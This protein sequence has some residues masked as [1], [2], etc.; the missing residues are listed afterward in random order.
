MRARVICAQTRYQGPP[1][2]QDPG[3]RFRARQ[4]HAKPWAWH[5]AKP[6]GDKARLIRDAIHAHPSLG[7]KELAEMINAS[8]ARKEDRIDVKRSDIAT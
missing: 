6:L 1:Q 4:A 7:N 2:K 5:P 8:D 3:K